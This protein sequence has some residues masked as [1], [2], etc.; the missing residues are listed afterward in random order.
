MFKRCTDKKYLE[1]QWYEEEIV[2]RYRDGSVKQIDQRCGDGC[3]G[4]IDFDEDGNEMQ[5]KS[6]DERMRWIG[7]LLN[8]EFERK[9]EMLEPDYK[10]KD[11]SES[12]EILL[13]QAQEM[14]LHNQVETLEVLLAKILQGKVYW[15]EANIK[16]ED[17]NFT[18]TG[19]TAKDKEIYDKAF[20]QITHWEDKLYP[21]EPTE[22]YL[23]ELWREKKGELDTINHALN[24]Y[25]PPFNS[26]K[27]KEKINT[28]VSKKDFAFEWAKY[29]LDNKD[30]DEPMEKFDL[31][32]DTLDKDGYIL[33]DWCKNR[34]MLFRWLTFGYTIRGKKFTAEQLTSILTTEG[35]NDWLK[36]EALAEE[37]DKN[38]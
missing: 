36:D 21:D 22:E 26:P 8:E 3:V 25:S 17:A 18:W 31:T 23:S 32:C 30:S 13:Y 38:R 15:N 14:R 27:F 28:Q 16:W 2:S 33:K 6:S 12:I 24:L 7:G 37:Q 19:G 20:A 5:F 35:F 4:V 29:W 10:A 11:V 9:M 34:M 1:S